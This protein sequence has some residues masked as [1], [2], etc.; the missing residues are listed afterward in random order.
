MLDS[1]VMIQKERGWKV[2]N[3]KLSDWDES[4]PRFLNARSNLDPTSPDL[5]A[6]RQLGARPPTRTTSILA[7]PFTSFLSLVDNRHVFG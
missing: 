1:G 5:D 6:P 4:Q 7:S 2:V 3:F